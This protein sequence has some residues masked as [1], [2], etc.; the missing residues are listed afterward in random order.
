MSDLRPQP[1]KYDAVLG[2]KIR[3]PLGAVVLG[4]FDSILQR[5]GSANLQVKMNALLDAFD[6]GDRGLQ[7]ITKVLEDDIPELRDF[8]YQHLMKRRLQPEIKKILQKNIPYQFF[9]L[10]HTIENYVNP[11]K[12]LRMSRDGSKIICIYYRNPE[13]KIW[14]WQSG[15]YALLSDRNLNPSNFLLA[16]CEIICQYSNTNVI[17]IYALDNYRL[18][19]E[20]DDCNSPNFTLALSEDRNTLVAFEDNQF[21][22]IWE[23]KTGKLIK[24]I[25]TTIRSIAPNLLKVI[26]NGYKIVAISNNKNLIV[27]D[28]IKG[29]NSQ[30]FKAFK[31]EIDFPTCLEISDDETMIFTGN[32]DGSIKMFDRERKIF[33]GSIDA[34][35]RAITGLKVINDC[36][37]ITAGLDN[38]IKIWNIN[39]ESAIEKE[40]EDKRTRTKNSRNQSLER[41]ISSDCY[42]LENV[43]IYPFPEQIDSNTFKNYINSINSLDLNRDRSK[44]IAGFADANIKIWDLQTKE[45]IANWQDKFTDGHSSYVN[46]LAITVNSQILISSGL[47]NTLKIWDLERQKLLRN[48]KTSNNLTSIQISPDDKKIITSTLDRAIEIWCLNTGNLLE[49]FN[50]FTAIISS[51][52]VSEE[53]PIVYSENQKIKIWDREQESIVELKGHLEPITHLVIAPDRR[54]LISASKDKTIKIW[55]LQKAKIIGTLKGHLRGVNC[56][57]ISPDGTKIVSGSDDGHLKIWDLLNKNL[58]KTIESNLYSIYSLAITPDGQKIVSASGDKQIKIWEL[59]SGQEINSLKGH[60]DAVSCLAI[61]PNGQT[62]VSAGKDSTIRLWGIN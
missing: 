33:L 52:A 47:D 58:L 18:L 21:V 20:L 22:K 41:R 5:F 35:L 56:I 30:S 39:R 31:S 36:T 55:D 25:Q 3:P 13:L 1:Q 15:E 59:N 8:V 54:T 10:L 53:T 51:L 57:A 43:D 34:H 26:D 62:I 4:G 49:R 40:L 24:N 6:S 9:K 45:I 7:L 16:D 46:N 28:L 37:L 17:R 38:T 42:S 2:G 61:T 50:N 32:K 60:T 29:K 12:L 48:I 44:I 23:L 19:F 27:Y 11:I 14:D